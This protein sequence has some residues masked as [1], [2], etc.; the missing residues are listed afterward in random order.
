MHHPRLVEGIRIQQTED[1]FIVFNGEQDRVH[2][3]N[4]TGTLVMMLCDGN[5]SCED[6]AALLQ[7]EYGLDTPPVQDVAE[8]LAQL[9]DEGLLARPSGLAS[10]EPTL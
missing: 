1:G 3:L 10:S 5:N 2:F 6:I 7:R 9:R 8:L 4:A